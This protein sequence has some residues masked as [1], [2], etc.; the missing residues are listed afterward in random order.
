M[1]YTVREY[2]YTEKNLMKKSVVALILSGCL[3]LPACGMFGGTEENG[4]DLYQYTGEHKDKN[5]DGVCDDCNEQVAITFDFYALND[6]HG[7]FDDTLSQPGV[8]ELSTYFQNARA[9]NENTVLLSSG[10]MWQGSPESYL[11][12]GNIVTE[13]MN[14]LDFSA[15]TLGNHE[16]DWGEE[17][18]EAN[19]ALAEFPL[20]AINVYD[21]ST[22]ARVE[23][24]QP[25]VTVEKNGVKIGIIGAIGDCYS[26]ISSDM[27]E[28][29]YFKK[30]GELTSLVKL[31]ADRLRREG[32]AFIVYSLHGDHRE[33]GEYDPSLSK[34]YVD[35]VFEGHTHKNYAQKD[36]GG[37]YHLQGGGDNDG[38]SYAQA[39][40]N[41]VTGTSEV[42]EAEFIS[43][44][45]YKQLEDAPVVDELLTKYQAQVAP[46][47]EVLGGN[48]SE[49]DSTEILKKC[50]ELYAEVGEAKWGEYE[51]VLGGGFMNTRA[52]YKLKSGT[53]TYGDLINVLPFDNRL[54]LCSIKGK[55]LEEKFLEKRDRYYIHKTAFGNGLQV[56][57]EETYYIVTDSYT[58]QYRYNNLT[59]IAWYDE[60]VYARDL[61]ADYIKTGAW[62]L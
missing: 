3:L 24:C 19:A 34:G 47:K 30:D 42:N 55:D 22:N 48:G 16:Y 43:T 20:L 18:I 7:K 57:A 59:E 6:L 8:D 53:L 61:L 33:R 4:S 11:T 1:C 13:W 35:L 27:T 25:S 31:E 21:R 38:I 14:E 46:A 23:Y 62:E 36:S 54:V 29:V 60:N 10:D 56:D 2:E 12:R 26:S 49:R 28:G 17:A 51:I 5:D 44:S 39:T 32:A 37:V 40:I 9:K 45:R 58:S 52:P 41:Y 50:A 15:M